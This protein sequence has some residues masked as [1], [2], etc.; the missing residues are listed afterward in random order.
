MAKFN[1]KI[2]LSAAMS[3]DGK[4]ATVTGE[5]KLSSKKDLIRLHKH[6]HY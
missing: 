4:I 6:C 1:P 3:L 5:S 2:I